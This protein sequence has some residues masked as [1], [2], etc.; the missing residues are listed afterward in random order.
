MGWIWGTQAKLWLPTGQHVTISYDG[1]FAHL[2]EAHRTGPAYVRVAAFIKHVLGATN[3]DSCSRIGLALPCTMVG[4]PGCPSRT[5]PSSVSKFG[6]GDVAETECRLAE[7]L[8]VPV[9][10][11]NDGEAAAYSA[12]SVVNGRYPQLVGKTLLVLTVGTSIGAA[13]VVGGTPLIGRYP[14]RSSHLVL[15][16]AGPPCELHAGCW[17]MYAG[18]DARRKLAASLGL[19][20]PA[21]KPLDDKAIYKLSQAANGPASAGPGQAYFEALA[22]QLA[23]GIGMI[24]T[25]V[26]LDAVIIAGGLSNAGDALRDPLVARLAKG[27][28]LEPTVAKDLQVLMLPEVS[29]AQGAAQ[30]AASCRTVD[31]TCACEGAAQT[32]DRLRRAGETPA[33]DLLGAAFAFLLP[34]LRS[35][36]HI[37]PILHT[38]EVLDLGLEILN[39]EAPGD[40]PML[41]QTILAALFHDSGNSGEPKNESKLTSEACRAD[42]SLLPRAVTQR[43]RHALR[44]AQ[45]LRE[46]LGQ[47]G[48]GGWSELELARLVWTIEHHDDPSVAELLADGSGNDLRDH[49]FGPEPE[50]RL[51][52]ILREADRLAMLRT[53]RAGLVTDLRRKR[54]AGKPWD[55][56]QQLT[57]NVRRHFDEL[58]LYRQVFGRLASP[59]LVWQRRRRSIAPALASVCSWRCRKRRATLRCLIGRVSC[60][61]A[62]AK[63]GS[64][65]DGV[66]GG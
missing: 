2:P 25:V 47:I 45:I 57:W 61:R 22:Q 42:P 7:A 19:S 64:Q 9:Q 1:E 43:R 12:A 33:A 28:F 5:I 65:R 4:G 66:N 35:G 63:A 59:P 44:S 23:R 32:E 49:L 31:E 40:G 52:V 15:D 10:I 27:D 18:V 16:P 34:Y 58:Q 62:D 11:L 38:V 24:A 30:Y 46:F 53:S 39:E 26:P 20:D 3:T 50:N 60:R 41:I 6:L 14:S 54:V 17:K 48:A 8:Q 29:P 37:S 21:G 13:F 51:S 56:M 55:P 36:Q